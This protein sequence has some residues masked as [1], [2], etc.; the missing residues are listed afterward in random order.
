[1]V[2]NDNSIRQINLLFRVSDLCRC[3]RSTVRQVKEA[4]S[5]ELPCTVMVLLLLISSV[6]GVST[7]NLWR[8]GLPCLQE[9]PT[10]P[11]LNLFRVCCLQI[12][13]QGFRE[14]HLLLDSVGR[15]GHF[16][17]K[18]AGRPSRFPRWV[19]NGWQGSMATET[20]DWGVPLDACFPPWVLL[21]LV[22]F[23][24]LVVGVIQVGNPQR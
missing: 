3:C 9:E 23:L 19:T 10:T 8:D 4:A 13:C 15:G 20:A 7:V 21:V 2:G 11:L 22:L 6:F 12:H 5:M 14:A 18:T 1:M 17:S 16:Q 24:L